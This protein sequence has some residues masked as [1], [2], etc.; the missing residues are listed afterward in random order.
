MIFHRLAKGRNKNCA[1]LIRQFIQYQFWVTDDESV[2]NRAYRIG[3]VKGGK[4]KKN[5]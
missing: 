1:D 5:R 4:H 2:I 3:R